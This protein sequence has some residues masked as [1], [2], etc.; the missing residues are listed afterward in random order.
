MEY[1]SMALF[2]QFSSGVGR[3][4]LFK[5]HAFGCPS[6]SSSFQISEECQSKIL[7]VVS[8]YVKRGRECRG[9]HPEA[10]SMRDVIT[11]TEKQQLS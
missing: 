1:K 10:G 7:A 11:H 4:Q 6:L 2:I 5:T 3:S 8:M 9:Y